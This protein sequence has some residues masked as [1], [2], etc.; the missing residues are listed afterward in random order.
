MPERPP[1]AYQ[2]FEREEW[3]KAVGTAME[4]HRKI[5]HKWADLSHHERARFESDQRELKK[6]YDRDMAVFKNSDREQMRIMCSMP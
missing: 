3:P 2:L 1:D 6:Q 5:R 4:I